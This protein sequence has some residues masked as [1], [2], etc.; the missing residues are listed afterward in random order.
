[1]LHLVAF[2]FKQGHVIM[3]NKNNLRPNSWTHQ[4]VSLI[5]VTSLLLQQNS[6]IYENKGPT[7]HRGS[8]Q[9]SGYRPCESWVI[10]HLGLLCQQGFGPRKLLE[11][12]HRACLSIP[13]NKS[14]MQWST[15]VF[16][17]LSLKFVPF[18]IAVIT[19]GGKVSCKHV[20][21]LWVLLF[22]KYIATLMSSSFWVEFQIVFKISNFNILI[23]MFQSNYI[24]QSYVFF[25][26]IYRD[27][28]N[29]ENILT[30]MKEA[31]IEPG[32][33]TY[34]ALLNAYAEKGDIDHVKQVW[35]M[36]CKSILKS[37]CERVLQFM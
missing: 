32:P 4:Q 35:F 26:I 14:G 27:M 21:C 18:F 12:S 36:L 2:F 28:E 17:L 30:V 7:N 20:R 23:N 24:Q 34:L 33:D 37:L 3:L 5:N 31:G 6:W 19:Y 29:A 15:L 8:V 1:M 13:P 9:C 25:E 22:Q 16:L 10:F 11:R